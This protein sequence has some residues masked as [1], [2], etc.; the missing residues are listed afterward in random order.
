MIGEPINLVA[1]AIGGL[2]FGVQGWLASGEK[3]EP[4]TFLKGVVPGIIAGLVAGATQP[5]W[6]TALLAGISGGVLANGTSKVMDKNE[7]L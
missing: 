4:K 5:D 3:F 1:G 2:I 7:I 6:I